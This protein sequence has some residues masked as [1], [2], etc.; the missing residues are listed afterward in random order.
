MI[1]N[2]KLHL[3][4]LYYEL[5]FDVFFLS[6]VTIEVHACIFSLSGSLSSF[7]DQQ[8]GS[9]IAK[10]APTAEAYGGICGENIDIYDRFECASYLFVSC[11]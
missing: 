11:V 9:R 10:Y 1:C 3:I 2:F 8:G 5:N 4:F 7:G 6:C